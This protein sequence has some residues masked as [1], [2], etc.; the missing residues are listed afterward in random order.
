MVTG[1]CAMASMVSIQSETKRQLVKFILVGCLN[2]LF[3]F[4]VYSFFI[5]LGC[6]YPVAALL[7]TCFGIIF[8]FKTLGTFVFNHK[9]NYAIFRFIFVY[10]FLYGFNLSLIRVFQLCSLNL[11]YSGLLAI[12]LTAIFAFFLNKYAV[13]RSTNIKEQAI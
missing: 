5:F 6:T 3:G 11:Y 4:T 8:N 10:I 2:T 1:N 7:S 12:L 9:N 13:F